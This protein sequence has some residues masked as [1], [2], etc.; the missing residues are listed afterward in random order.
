MITMKTIT[1]LQYEN[2]RLINGGYEY[3]KFI[4][5]LQRVVMLC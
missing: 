5:K 2:I 4:Q 3:M 1:S